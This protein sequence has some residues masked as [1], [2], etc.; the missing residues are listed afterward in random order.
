MRHNNFKMVLDILL[1]FY[2]L[3]KIPEIIQISLYNIF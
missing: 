3:K 2:K 1:K